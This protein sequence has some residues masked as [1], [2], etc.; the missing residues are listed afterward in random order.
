MTRTTDGNRY[1]SGL[2]REVARQLNLAGRGFGYE[3][4]VI[5]YLKPAKTSKYN[6][7]FI[8]TKRDGSKM[9]IEAKGRFLT[10]DRQK[11]LLVRDQHPELDIRLLFQNANNK[12]SK[13]SKTT[14][15]KWCESKGILYADKSR[16]PPEWL[17]E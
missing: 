9:Y 15:A 3:N 1:R 10:A 4:E 8:I 14:Y 7:D 6:P 12:I 11:H 16:I 17:K 5:P 2:E 13:A